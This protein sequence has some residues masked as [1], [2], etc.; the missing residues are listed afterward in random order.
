M[1]N[2]IDWDLDIASSLL[3]SFIIPDENASTEEIMMFA[4]TFNGYYYK[5]DRH[6]CARFSSEIEDA[7]NIDKNS[8]AQQ[9]TDDIRCAM[10]WEYRVWR[11]QLTEPFSPGF[12]HI[13][14][15]EIKKEVS[16]I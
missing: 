7:Y 16:L 3:H 15:R 6:S 13:L 11:N 8:L 14:L 1:K 5:G 9:S 12:M 4:S 10:F 2:K